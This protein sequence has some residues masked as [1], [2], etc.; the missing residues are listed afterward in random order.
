M[1]KPMF[2]THVIDIDD[3]VIVQ[4]EGRLVRSDAAYRLRNVVQGCE[5]AHTIILDMRG[6]DA[7]EGGG[8][9]MLAFLQ[10]WANDN[11][12]ELRLLNPSQY[13][14]QRLKQFEAN[15]NLQFEFEHEDNI[16]SAVGLPQREH[17]VSLNLAA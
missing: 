14:E 8:L 4:C 1:K 12:I 17:W 7:V 6:L 5:R 11:G 15:R 13:V 9:G 16:L 3:V 2:T 10:Q